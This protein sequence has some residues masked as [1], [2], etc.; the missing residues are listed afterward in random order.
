LFANSVPEMRP[1]LSHHAEYS[2]AP[3]VLTVNFI[4][5]PA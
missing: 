2:S 1:T 5:A 4:Y 3:T